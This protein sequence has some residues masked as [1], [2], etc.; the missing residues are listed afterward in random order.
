MTIHVSKTPRT[1]AF[2]VLAVFA[3]S[4]WA[5]AG[6][7]ERVEICHV[8]PDDPDAA[9]T[10]SVSEKAVATH[11]AHGDLLEPC[12]D[13]CSNDAGTCDDSNACT[14]DLCVGRKCSNE[15]IAA[16]ACDDNDDLTADGCE[17]ATGC[18]NYCLPLPNQEPCGFASGTFTLWDE[19]TESCE[20]ILTLQVSIKFEADTQGGG[21][22]GAAVQ[23][24]LDD[25]TPALIDDLRSVFAGF[26]P[27]LTLA[28]GD[29]AA[30]EPDERLSYLGQLIS[31]DLLVAIKSSSLPAGA[32]EATVVSKFQTE[33][34]ANPSMFASMEQRLTDAVN[35]G[36]T[37]S[38]ITINV[39]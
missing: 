25:A 6:A 34:S 4:S 7:P 1:L 27:S 5:H 37:V 18:V 39:Y 32:T 28:C 29:I 16:S 17:P 8:P 31:V 20:D 38:Y 11:L 19:I 14:D 13:M 33:Y 12:G 9:Q 10:I 36:E 2:A 24:R 35:T 15:P 26:T 30:L 21:Y 23:Q 22:D 3:F